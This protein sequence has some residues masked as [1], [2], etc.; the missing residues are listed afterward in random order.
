VSYGALASFPLRGID[1]VLDAKLSCTGTTGTTSDNVTSGKLFIL[2][3]GHIPCSAEVGGSVVGVIV[4]KT[5]AG[6]IKPTIVTWSAESETLSPN[7]VNLNLPDAGTAT[8]TGSYANDVTAPLVVTSVAL[9]KGPCSSKAQR[10]FKF[11]ASLSIAPP[12][13]SAPNALL[14][15][16]MN[17]YDG[18]GQFPWTAANSEGMTYRPGLVP[19]AKDWTQISAGAHETFAIKTDG[20]L[21]G[22]GS[23]ELG[24]LG[25]GSTGDLD[26]GGCAPTY[27][28]SCTSVPHQI[29]TD[30]AWTQVS[31]GL[32]YTM[33]IKTD[34][35]LWGWG[36]DTANSVLGDGATTLQTQPELIDHSGR[37]TQVSASDIHTFG[38]KAG[39]LYGWGSNQ[40][41]ELG[42]ACANPCRTPTPIGSL[43]DQWLEVSAGSNG[44]GG[45]ALAIKAADHS[46]WA[47]GSGTS[48][49]LGD[50]TPLASL[51]GRQVITPEPIATDKA[52]AHVSAG[53][54]HTIAITTDGSLYAWGDNAFGELGDGST[55]GGVV[56]GPELIT[57]PVTATHPNTWSH[58]SAGL[59]YSM[60]INTDGTLWGWGNPSLGQL[61][62]GTTY[63]VYRNV[64][65][66]DGHSSLGQLIPQQV[67]VSGLADNLW[68]SVSTSAWDTIALNSGA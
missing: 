41:Q 66:P 15:W 40:Y 6:H 60:A 38:I 53:T 35:S 62:D 61:G 31:T 14:S 22:W 58:V 32:N 4:W 20:T 43:S 46:L 25:V 65:Y 49:Q 64:V 30:N 23:N 67:V 51:A 2:S 29:G 36:D 10:G 57:L 3:H 27:P 16:G 44:N 48:G 39:A 19:G 26:T 13:G 8:I 7:Q 5:S 18:L 42:V 63:G 34:G 24:L 50:N 55:F 37:W 21:W 9:P 47:W 56:S 54:S 68:T 1:V 12:V 45:F 28:I 11:T 52:W 59:T 33:A 17:P